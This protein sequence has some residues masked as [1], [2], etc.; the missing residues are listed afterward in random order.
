MRAF[1]V[2]NVSLFVKSKKTIGTF[3]AMKTGD[4]S[5]HLNHFQ[6]YRFKQ[7]IRIF[8]TNQTMLQKPCREKIS[9]GQQ[10][11]P[12]FVMKIGVKKQFV[13]RFQTQT[14]PAKVPLVAISAGLLAQGSS[15]LPCLPAQQNWTVAFY[16]FRHPLQ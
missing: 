13:S 11:T 2:K 3:V 9:A 6:E 4:T 12:T 8:M 5:C 7:E 15:Y 16:G 14:S 10:K 1:F